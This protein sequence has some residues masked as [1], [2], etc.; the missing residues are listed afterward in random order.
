MPD[1]VVD[2]ATLAELLE[3]VG[4]DRD[5]LVELVETYLPRARTSW[6]SCAPR[7]RPE[8]RR[9]PGGRPT[10]SSRRARASG[11][12]ASRR[13]AGRSRRR[14]PRGDLAGLDERVDR[15]A[16]T[17]DEVEAALRAAV[18]AGEAS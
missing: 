9:S 14:P 16:A 5:F 4:G 3:T 11:P 17:Y 13:S 10:P 8:T 2:A 15:A 7:W 1:A 18:T 6:P 12:S